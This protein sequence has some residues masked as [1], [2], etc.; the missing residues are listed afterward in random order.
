MKSESYR[1]LLITVN[2]LKLLPSL[3]DIERITD[4]EVEIKR[5][6]DF[7]WYSYIDKLENEQIIKFELFAFTLPEQDMIEFYSFTKKST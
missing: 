1:E 5:F 7:C 4:I 2:F 6:E 3:R